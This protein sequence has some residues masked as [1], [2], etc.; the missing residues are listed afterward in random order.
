M[1]FTFNTT[2]PAS[3]HSPATDQPIMLANNVANAGI[4]SIDH[5]GFNV[6]E[7]GYHKIIHQRQ[8]S[9]NTDPAAIA[10]V[11]QLYV[12]TVGGDTQLFAET[13]AG[14]ISQLTGGSAS[15]T[16][17]QFIGNVQLK[18][19]IGTLSVL[20][21]STSITFATAFTSACYN[22]QVSFISN[23]AGASGNRIWIEVFDVNVNG[24]K[25]AS[26]ATANETGFYWMAIGL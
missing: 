26:L 1:T 20:P 10:G 16:G 18:W 25:C 8:T 11:N 5:N 3:N 13:G 14:G 2:I 15:A 19:G 4:W 21:G 12:K 17:F 24:F 23:I 9:G 6:A 22:V 7:G